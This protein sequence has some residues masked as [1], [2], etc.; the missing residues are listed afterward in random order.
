MFAHINREL[1]DGTRDQVLSLAERF[2]AIL[3]PEFRRAEAEEARLT[4]HQKFLRE[5]GAVDPFLGTDVSLTREAYAG[6]GEVE[7][8]TWTDGVNLRRR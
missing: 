3:L 1:P 6:L 7:P 2:V 8:D 4:N 5:A